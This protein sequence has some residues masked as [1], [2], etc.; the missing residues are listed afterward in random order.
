M[1]T[2]EQATSLVQEIINIGLNGAG[3]LSSAKSL[4]D[5]YRSG[6]ASVEESINALIRWEASKSFGYGFVTG[7]GGLI[8]LP[9]TLPA[10]LF[11]TWA[12][13]AR[14][15][16]AIAELKGYDSSCPQV[17]T[18]ILFIMIGDPIKELGRQVAMEVGKKVSHQLI[19][20]IPGHMIREINKQV[21]FRLLTKAGQ[22]GTVNLIKAVPF[23]GGLIGG[24][25]DAYA[26]NAVGDVA[27]A[28]L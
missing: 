19:M 28:V 12:V 25:V 7:L 20:K 22:K 15:V 6:Y 13:Q 2:A 4:A 21:G 9:V 23:I 10:A 11:A 18:M 14:L 27:N 3:P 26:T 17:Q 5:E 16:G 8:T 1:F 24:G